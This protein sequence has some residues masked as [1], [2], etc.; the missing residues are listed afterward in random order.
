MESCL[1][2]K[3]NVW[4]TR[5]L[6]VIAEVTHVSDGNS[7]LFAGIKLRVEIGSRG[8]RRQHKVAV[9]ALK[10]ALDCFACANRLDAVYGG[11]LT[12]INDQRGVDAAGIDQVGVTVV[13]RRSEMRRRSRCHS[14][15][16]APSIDHDDGATA[17][18]ELIRGREPG[19]SAE[20]ITTTSAV[21]SL[22]RAGACATSVS[23]QGDLVFSWATF[24]ARAPWSG[25]NGCSELNVPGLAV[26]CDRGW[27]IRALR[28]G[29]AGGLGFEPRLTKSESAV[30]P[31]N[32]PPNPDLPRAAGIASRSSALT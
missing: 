13:E 4:R 29:L 11:G 16:D 9:K 27:T 2:G 20:P 6:G 22:A 8:L 30:L 21:W 1:M 3:R 28:C 26:Q 25:N 14:A 15:A 12:L 32:Y 10:I 31:L 23:I 7:R 19:N 18:G 17:A 24:M 5:F